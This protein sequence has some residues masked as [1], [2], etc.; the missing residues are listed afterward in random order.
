M[1]R[2][3]DDIY[4]RLTNILDALNNIGIGG[5][6]GGVNF[7]LDGI[8]N[9]FKTNMGDLSNNLD[10]F[11]TSFEN[12]IIKRQ[13]KNGDELERILKEQNEDL[14]EAI[15]SETEAIKAQMRIIAN[16]HS[17]KAEKDNAKAEIKRLREVIEGKKTDFHDT[18][19]QKAVDAKA[20]QLKQQIA[21]D[22]EDARRFRDSKI[23]RSFSKYEDSVGNIRTAGKVMQS[24]G[25]KGG[26]LGKGASMAGG[27]LI[28][29]SSKL[30]KA[31]PVVGQ[32]MMVM[33]LLGS[34]AKEAAEN[35]SKQI[36]LENKLRDS[37]TKLN[38]ANAKIEAE[39]VLDEYRT[40]VANSTLDFNVLIQK[41]LNK[42]RIY[43]QRNQAALETQTSAMTDGYNSAAWAAAAKKR[44]IDLQEQIQNR[45]I[46][47]TEEINKREKELNTLRF[48]NNQRLREVQKAQSL[49]DYKKDVISIQ[50]EQ[51]DY[52]KEKGAKGILTGAQMAVMGFDTDSPSVN[53]SNAASSSKAVKYDKAGSIAA[54][55]TRAA[56]STALGQ[57]FGLGDGAEAVTTYARAKENRDLNRQQNSL[58]AR[59]SAVAISKELSETFKEGANTFKNL[60][61][62]AGRELKNV[63]D[64][65]SKTMKD[66]YAQF[67]Q[68]VEQWALNFDTISRRSSAGKGFTTAEQMRLYSDF[69]IKTIAGE[70]NGKKGLA[71]LAGMSM[72]D[73]LQ[74]QNQYGQGTG[75]SLVGNES[76]LLKT[77]SM[78]KY[79][80]D[81]GLAVELANSS[82]IFNMGMG[83]AMDLMYD[84]TK[85]V[86]KM[87]LD[88]RKYM[89]DMVQNLKM[90]QKYNFKGG[91]K[92]MMEMAKWAQN[93]RFDMNK[94]PALLEDILNG[95]LEGI[96]EKG[97]KLQVLGGN[98]AMGADPLAMMY[99]AMEDPAALAKRINGMTKGMGKFNT[100][101]GQVEF[102]GM[103]QRQL[104]LLAQ[105]TG[106][107]L[108]DV[109]NQASYGIKS[110]K[111]GNIF[112]SDL[113]E[114][115]KTSLINKAY[116]KDGKWVVNGINGQAMAVSG[117]TKNNIDQLQAET[118]EGKVEQLLTTLVSYKEQ[119]LGLTESGMAKFTD[120]IIGNG[121]LDE[122]QKKRQEV[123]Q[124]F[125]NKKFEEYL[126]VVKD[127]IEETD[128]SFAENL[129]AN[130]SNPQAVIVGQLDLIQ[131]YTKDILDHLGT[132]E[133]KASV[134]EEGGGSQIDS[135]AADAWKWFMDESN[136]G[137]IT[138]VKKLL[139][140]LKGLSGSELVKKAKKIDAFGTGY[141]DLLD[142]ME[143]A[144]M[145]ADDNAKYLTEENIKAMMKA[146]GIADG[147]LS[148]N[149]S[150]MLTSASN[151]TPIHD[152]SVQI[153]KSDPK[154]TALF[155]KTG[156]PFDTLF[157]GIFTKINEI[158]S[159][160]PKSMEYVMPM[161]MIN[162]FNRVANS[163]DTAND[164]TIKIDTVKIELNGKLELTS[165]NGQS[166]D[167][168]KEIQNNPMLLRSLSE[169]I[170]ESINKNINGGKSTYTGG[171]PTPRFK[172][173]G[174]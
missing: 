33:Q 78:G 5:G 143:A 172:G 168:I 128:K 114:E 118:H 151:I 39:S 17:T 55:T 132:V 96:I 30:G 117:I 53:G 10:K 62:E 25:G 84:M 152:G 110:A 72:D 144:G 45:N 155:A 67:S 136:I 113:D 4:D 138:D 137:N 166:I 109:K 101:T 121:N 15:K 164:G 139:R 28:K 170:S 142:A 2:T 74:M 131:K 82:E 65:F 32:I 37:A 140:Q 90:A 173:M 16:E 85:K 163:K 97:A 86:N 35:F 157:N 52:I 148:S 126:G 23:G 104:Q 43:G 54:G 83:G 91:V 133:S 150:S 169:M 171:T 145:I 13:K 56:A 98:F 50:R 47:T 69:M 6:N 20:N 135:E 94:L 165:G 41:E 125:Y 49:F 111:M 8:F 75:R 103:E 61:A 124:E 120:R 77:A 63:A 46:A 3:F 88:G 38:V 58:I 1:A 129:N 174:F 127:N 79:L 22:R 64:E 42:Q 76:D 51:S 89:K 99:E 27:E 160:L 134:A 123:M 18:D 100:K 116:L 156:G 26:I 34:A 9:E 119:E 92:G 167:I 48:E 107:D 7:N 115:Q 21:E 105:Y 108:T 57:A 112:N 29:L 161:S 130:L 70:V 158:S 44:D 102:N 95:G 87:G 40:D 147:V 146:A 14:A 93:V 59:E 159:V 149:G 80:G 12:D 11:N 60:Q 106:Q 19:K 36:D 66:T 24:F 81:N 68:K 31:I 153:A 141:D 71:E 73:I 162:A 154:D 122:S